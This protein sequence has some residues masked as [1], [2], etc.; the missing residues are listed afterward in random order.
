MSGQIF[1]SYRREDSWGVAGRLSDRLRPQFGPKQLFMDLDSIELGENF[2]KVIETTVARCD[3][4]LA[5]IGNNWLNTKDES[6]GRRLDNPVDWVRKEIGTA[7]DR[8]IR[9]IPIL[10]GGAIMPRSTDLPEDLKPLASL[11]ALRLT[12]DSFEG[13]LQRLAGAIRQVLEKAAAEERERLAAEQRQREE[14]QRLEAEARQKEE[15]ERLEAEQHEKERLATE[16]R[17]KERLEAEQREK[18]R[19]EGEEREKERLAAELREKERLEA[20]PREGDGAPHSEA[21]RVVSKPSQKS[22]PHHAETPPIVEKNRPT[23]RKSSAR[24]ILLAVLA[25]VFIA[26]VFWFGGRGVQVTTSLTPTPQSTP[27]PTPEST[28]G[29]GLTDPYPQSTP[30]PRSTL[31]RYRALFIKSP[32]SAP[33]PTPTPD[34]AFYNNRGMDFYWRKDYDEAISN[35]NEAIRLS[36]N[37]ADAYFKRG[38]AYYDKK[39]YEK[40]IN[41]YNEAIRLDPNHAKVYYYRGLAYRKQWKNDEAQADFDKAKQLGYTGPQ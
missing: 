37:D 2:V 31:D 30:T 18:E 13:D 14:K 41:D 5:V 20:E 24:I 12:S 26:G 19:L 34:A 11:N 1:I 23:E 40:A 4:L 8:H 25:L 21:V 27:V 10:V 7:L 33:T 28:H 6:G 38:N 9:V 36:P 15:K 3:V 17:E 35:Y 29:V 16:Q 39:D 22:E 32:Q